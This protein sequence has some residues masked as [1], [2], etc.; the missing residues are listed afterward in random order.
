MLPLI[1][2]LLDI[3]LLKKGPE[4][5]PRSWLVLYLCVGLWV[6][7]LL[8]M[9]ALLQNFSTDEAWVALSSWVLG[10]FCFALVLAFSGQSGRGLQ[11]VAALA[12]VG[13]II[14]LVMLAEL[15]FLTPFLGGNIANLGA[16]LV[17]LWSVPVKGHI[18]A[19]AIERHWYIG[20]V[21]AMSVFV[22]QYAF[23]SALTSNLAPDP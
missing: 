21:I 20:I 16:I 14:S 8:A 15:V 9:T 13:A 4:D 5:L 22:L 17:L 3:I 11:T 7:A 6:F 23:T 2:T 19:R 1:R 18:I 12:G 10:L